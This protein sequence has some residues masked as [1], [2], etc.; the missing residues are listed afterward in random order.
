MLR[1]SI[2]APGRIPR[3]SWEARKWHTYATFVRFC[4]CH[5]ASMTMLRV[6]HDM[7]LHLENKRFAR[8]VETKRVFRPPDFLRFWMDVVGYAGDLLGVGKHQSGIRMP[9]SCVLAFAMFASMTMFRFCNDMLLHITNK[10]FFSTLLERN[11]SFGILKLL[12]FSSK[13]NCSFYDSGSSI[14]GKVALPPQRGAY[15]LKAGFRASSPSFFMD[16]P[17]IA[18][19]GPRIDFEW[20]LDGF[21]IDFGSIW[22]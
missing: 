10:R 18:P 22:G 17:K 3:L 7:L 8:D 20:I 13:Q 11:T 16:R 15:F 1:F 4:I 9:L 6:F 14:L 19:R 5:L 2:F 12:L 21:G